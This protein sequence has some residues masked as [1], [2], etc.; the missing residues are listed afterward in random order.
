[1]RAEIVGIWYKRVTMV[2]ERPGRVVLER[3][4]YKAYCGVGRKLMATWQ[5]DW[6]KWNE[7]FV[8]FW[9]FYMIHISVSPKGINYGIVQV[10]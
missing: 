3:P 8:Y 10:S 4:G 9:P 6:E 1:M 2:Q 7:K 5:R